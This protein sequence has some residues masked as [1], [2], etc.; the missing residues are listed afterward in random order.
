MKKEKKFSLYIII[1]AAVLLQLISG[2]QYWYAHRVIRR[3]VEDRA[4]SE[5][6][7]K[8]LAIEKKLVVV[9]TAVENMAWAVEAKLSEPE[10]MFDLALR[11]VKQNEHITGCAIL[12]SPNYY[13]SKGYWFEPYAVRRADGSYETMQLGSADHDYHTIDI[14]VSYRF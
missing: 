10:E 8:R 2:V 4:N 9:E 11:T 6:N 1:A 14:Q 12:F 13:P 5:M 3:Q 7:I